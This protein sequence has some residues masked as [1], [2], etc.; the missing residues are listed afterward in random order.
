M[1]RIGTA[2]ERVWYWLSGYDRRPYY[3]RP[4]VLLAAAIHYTSQ[5]GMLVSTRRIEAAWK[6]ARKEGIG[7]AQPGEPAHQ[8]AVSIDDY[9]MTK[10][11]IEDEEL[12]FEARFRTLEQLA[13]IHR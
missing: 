4:Y 9:L 12:L 3:Y 7:R 2:C 5:T 8:D 10:L 13:F 1:R 11:E 6:L